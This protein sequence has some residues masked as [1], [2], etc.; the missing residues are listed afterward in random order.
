MRSV[1]QV[2]FIICLMFAWNSG[3]VSEDARSDKDAAPENIAAGCSRDLFPFCLE[4]KGRAAGFSV[5]LL[6]AA[7]KVSGKK[8]EFKIGD[9][10]Q[11]REELSSGVIRILPVMAR[12][13]EREALYE[14]TFPYLT[15]SNA[16]VVD[17]RNQGIRR[18]QDLAGKR[19]IVKLLDSADDY[20][21]N[22]GINATISR[23]ESYEGALRQVANGGQDA[24]II[25]KLA[26]SQRSLK[27]D[28]A[29]VRC[30]DLLA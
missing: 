26:F 1:R 23:V 6:Q 25:Q 8:A 21:T 2:A 5:E 29:T 11:L 14:F 4:E 10:A 20:I 27:P 12:M 16:I 17:K 7:L 18:P 9:W 22:S 30:A 13:K 28:L 19:V 3:A 24:A 15:M